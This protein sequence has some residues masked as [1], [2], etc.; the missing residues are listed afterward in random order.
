MGRG[1]GLFRGRE[2]DA[3]A[4]RKPRAERPA[5]SPDVEGAGEGT[6][7][8][9]AKD[10]RRGKH[11]EGLAG[12]A[13]RKEREHHDG[14]GGGYQSDVAPRQAQVAFLDRPRREDERRDGEPGQL[15]ERDAFRSEDG[16][17]RASSAPS[18]AS[19]IIAAKTTGPV[20]R[21]S[22]RTGFRAYWISAKANSAGMRIAV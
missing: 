9:A 12:R 2:P 19:A 21:L 5:D 13:Q 1:T 10:D 3:A 18:S 14:G 8:Y 7:D 4:T 22:W 16:G 15:R 11:Q 17:S 6:V 20:R